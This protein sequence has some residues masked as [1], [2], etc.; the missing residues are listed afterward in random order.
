MS[1]GSPVSRFHAFFTLLLMPFCLGSNSL[2]LSRV[3][4]SS[5][6][7]F[8]Q[9]STISL[10]SFFCWSLSS[11]SDRT[12]TSWRIMER[13]RTLSNQAVSGGESYAWGTYSSEMSLNCFGASTN[14]FRI[15]LA[16]SIA[17][18]KSPTLK[19]KLIVISSTALSLAHQKV[20]CGKVENKRRMPCWLWG[21][22]VC[23]Q[24]H[25]LNLGRFEL[26]A[27]AKSSLHGKP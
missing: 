23:T 24:P 4:S 22:V 26:D 19:P 5:S 10:R 1:P 25:G 2:Y 18:V 21:H 17:A 20:G 9:A 27:L 13:L 3:L 6:R 16:S 12:S 11:H 15:L 8:R 7:T 14:S